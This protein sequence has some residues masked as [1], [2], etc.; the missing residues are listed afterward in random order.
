MK[1]TVSIDMQI[2]NELE[3]TPT[4]WAFLDYLHDVTYGEF[5]ANIETKQV[6]KYL[7]LRD[8][9]ISSIVNNMAK[10][11]LVAISSEN[12]SLIRTTEMWRSAVSYGIQTVPQTESF[13][14]RAKAA[15][16]IALSKSINPEIANIPIIRNQEEF[17]LIEKK[18]DLINTGS[19]AYT[20]EADR[21][22]REFDSHRKQIQP[23]FDINLCEGRY[24]K[25]AYDVMRLHLLDTTHIR[26]PEHYFAA[27]RWLFNSKAKEAEF[28][29]KSINSISK[30]IQHYDAIE[31]AA[32]SNEEELKMN[33]E[34]KTRVEVMRK[35]G[36]SE[37]EI[38][39]EISKMTGM[40]K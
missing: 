2:M 17:I 8:K 36:S 22:V 24:S 31:M 11:G 21:V 6:A 20:E 23:T 35:H 1:K 26:I 13:Q 38:I 18:R 40:N 29:R 39:R 15:T 16:A 34:I 3:L 32:M 5:Y 27:I 12:T 37:E 4:W 33:A 28:W 30:L 9:D 10:K 25:N 7:G 14:R 19:T